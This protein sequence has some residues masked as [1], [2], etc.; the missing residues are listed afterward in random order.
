LGHHP[1]QPTAY[2]AGADGTLRFWTMPPAAPKALPNGGAVVRAFATDGAS[3]AL[4]AG[5]AVQLAS[6]TD[7]SLKGAFT[8]DVD[9]TS[10]AVGGGHVFAGTAGRDVLAWK[11]K[12]P[13]AK[14]MRLPAHEGGVTGVSVNPAG[15]QLATCGK[16]GLVRLWAVP[17]SSP[18]LLTANAGLTC[19]AVLPDGKR[20]VAAGTDKAVR[21]FKVEGGLE[22]Q[23][24]G[25]PGPVRSLTVLSDGKTPAS[26]GDDGS[27]RIWSGKADTAS[28]LGAHEGAVLSLA[29]LGE[30]L[31]SS[32]ADGS[33]KLWQ[34]AAATGKEALAHPGAVLAVAVS[35]DGARLVTA[36]DDRQVRL[37]SLAAAK[38]ERT[39][40][41]PG[42]TVSSVAWSRDGGRVAAG[43]ADKSVF[44]WE[45]ASAKEVRKL[46]GLP[47][48]VRA[49]ALPADGKGVLA[50]FSDGSAAQ[51]DLATGKEMKQY[52]GPK[53]PATAMVLPTRGDTAL[54]AHEDGTIASH[55]LA[56]GAAKT[57]KAAGP[58]TALAVRPDGSAV[59]A[60][61]GKQVQLFSL[62]GK[63][64]GKVAAPAAVRGLAYSTDSKRLA[65]ACDD[66][67]ALAYDAEGRLMESLPHDGAVHGVAF[68]SEGRTLV[69]AGA[70]KT[71]R[72]RLIS[73][74]W[75]ARAAGPV[76]Q[77]VN[78]TRGIYA[79]CGD[80]NV[81]LIASADGKAAPA[82]K[83]HTGAVLGLSATA[84]GTK[85]ATI[86][87]DGMA[88]VWEAGKPAALKEVKLPAAASAVA[89]SPNATRLAVSVP[90]G[91]GH[92]VHVFDAVSGQPLLRLGE[93]EVMTASVLAWQADNRTLLV[94]GDDGKAQWI[95]VAVQSAFEAHKGGVTAA[96][97][98]PGGTTLL[99]AGADRAV[100][101]WNV[102]TGKAEKSF[103]PLPEAASG[104]A[105]SRDGQMVAATAGKKAYLW[106][107]AD[108]KPA[109]ELEAPSAL[110]SVSFNSDRTRLLTGGADGR[111]RVWDLAL[112]REA[113]AILHDGP[114]LAVL[115]HPTAPTQAYT[116]GDDKQAWAHT[117][118]LAR[119]VLAGAPLTSLTVSATGTFVCVTGADGKVR[120]FNGSSGALEKEYACG[121]KP[122]ASSA[123]SKNEAYVAAAS[124]DN[125][126]RLF[127]SG[128]G[129]EVLAV[130]LPAA[131]R[132]IAYS[133]DGRAVVAAL[134]NGAVTAIDVQFTPGAEKP[135]SLGK[136]A[137]AFTHGADAVSVAFAKDGSTF[138]TAGSD[139]SVK[140]W[141]LASDAPTRS[142][143]HPANVNALA[144]DREGKV[145]LTGCGDGKLRTFDVAKGALLKQIDAHAPVMMVAQGIY[146]VAVSPDGKY[147]A[148]A[149][150]DGSAKVFELASG[151]L[152]RELKAFKEKEAPDG[153]SDSVLTVCFSPDGK[154]LATAGMDQKI[155]VWS[156]AEGKLT[157]RLDNPAFKGLSHPGWV[158]ALRWTSDG[159]HLVAAGA[160]PRLRGYLSVWE[161]ATGKLVSGQEVNA[162]TIFALS[163]SPDEKAA[164]IGTG[165]S[166][167]P[168]T[169]VHQAAILKLPGR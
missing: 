61:S 22:R 154:L 59:A 3:L 4:A 37:W 41:G 121:D 125:K 135:E 72:V 158:Y 6:L 128:E 62:D 40:T 152:I 94:A 143:P 21:L 36:C 33:V 54:I 26:G 48:A 75:Q 79:A 32:S 120:R 90:S 137:Q 14:P 47:A 151:K 89:L 29:T 31:I 66:G 100:T 140:G 101:V 150:A 105:W 73:L 19:L 30:R 60:A 144:F 131:P 107:V 42:M 17:V 99:T 74:V 167:R 86:G 113:M 87:A 133:P 146:G 130:P 147:G 93:G 57:W 123:V 20:V 129:K 44:V 55:P 34:P 58:V 85:L 116:A 160:A 10:A 164:A 142:L 166:I 39:Y 50:A 64:V 153:H 168:E 103:G 23:L 71:A 18:R 156:V 97:Y 45:S 145:L 114:A 159:K 139:K 77:A 138:W 67:K 134:A 7:G 69:S 38:L 132:A 68:A 51:Y 52:P 70:D 118:P 16:D 115:A 24:L 165:G 111:A 110:G 102:A 46:T 136:T 9:V 8:A 122:V 117:A 80:G 11:V 161:A 95:D 1:T 163:L 56:G 43:G 27:I 104:I 157:Q 81:L 141:K 35:P 98:A 76:A 106:T 112:K 25:H 119:I 65:V 82:M 2:T 63:E 169:D 126:L 84:D 91:K 149:S 88:R 124:A 162:G 28:V 53:S 96:A 12:E 109:G 5:K 155:K 148:S 78:T 92:H 15:T 13:A 83:A 127:S 49:V 108:G